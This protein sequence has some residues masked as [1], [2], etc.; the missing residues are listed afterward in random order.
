MKLLYGAM[1]VCW[2]AWAGALACSGQASPGHGEF[3][4]NWRDAKE[5][6]PTE[7]IARAKRLSETERR[8]LIRAIEAQLRPS[9]ADIGIETADQ[10][11]AI[12]E[13]TRIGIVDLGRGASAVIAQ[14]SY[15][16]GCSPTGN[17]PI[18]VF[19]VDGSRYR[20]ILEGEGQTFTIQPTTTRGHRDIVLG[21]HWSASEAKLTIYVFNGQSYEQN[22]CYIA[23]WPGFERRHVAPRPRR[24]K[25]SPCSPSA[26]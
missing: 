21:T 25:L 17:C 7:T 3:R 14:G 9:A 1:I 11:S 15:A 20:I 13:A 18:W 5:L 12:A 23:E 8:N 19:R 10:L 26:S 4:W 24:P 2:W 22:G 16:S 6:G